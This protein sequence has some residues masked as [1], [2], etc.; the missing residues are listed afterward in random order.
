LAIPIPF[1]AGFTH[2]VGIGC[3]CYVLFGCKFQ[4]LLGSRHQ[5]H[6]KLTSLEKRP[7]VFA[8]GLTSLPIFCRWIVAFLTGFIA[9]KYG[10]TPY[11]ILLGVFISI[12]G[13][14]FK[15][16]VWWK[17]TR[18]FVEMESE[19]EQGP[20][21]WEWFLETTFQKQDINSVTQAGTVNK[22]E[23]RNDL[24]LLPIVLFSLNFD[25][26]K[27]LE[28]SNRQFI[29]RM[30]IGQLLQEKCLII[31]LKKQCFFGNVIATRTSIF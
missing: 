26:R 2:R 13:L 4:V 15:T 31:I 5:S 20:H 16:A 7:C 11:P 8:M 3:F 1:Y 28:L 30:G 27:H 17:N 14:V 29:Q 6:G 24:G 21:S 22:T 23:W 9:N 12:V 25:Q 19:T 10:G 18:I